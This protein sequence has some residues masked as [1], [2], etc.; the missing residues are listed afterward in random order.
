MKRLLAI[1]LFVVALT[2]PGAAVAFERSMSTTAPPGLSLVDADARYLKLDA[3]NDP[4]TGLLD[5]RLGVQNAGATNSCFDPSGDFCILGNL[6]INGDIR[7]SRSGTP[8][9]FS[10]AQGVLLTG[11]T[12]LSSDVVSGFNSI[13]FNFDGA[14]LD[15]GTGTLDYLTSDGT[16]ISFPG[17]VTVLGG[18]LANNNVRN[19]AGTS[20]C[21]VP[22]GPLCILDDMDVNGDIIDSRTNSPV[23][24]SDVDGVDVPNG[25]LS[26]GGG[27]I[28]VTGT[29]PTFS[30][31]GT[32]PSI[33]GAD[34]AGRINVGTGFTNLCRINFVTTY[35]VAPAC[36]VTG[37]SSAINYTSVPSTTQL[38]ISSDSD[39]A[40]NVLNYICVGL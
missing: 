35:A 7:D 38:M 11:V 20:G 23:T 31:C 16:G 5:I 40:S 30:T 2:V 9:T 8:V 34:M 33:V 4:I 26:V 36:T 27:Q 29:D 18:L 19:N 10:D 15:L 22:G 37:N 1:A 39:M 14:R 3:S 13:E 25:N 12:T 32:S 21:N 28:E 6:D 24:F 17:R